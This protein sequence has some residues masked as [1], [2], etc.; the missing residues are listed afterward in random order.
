MKGE[1]LRAVRS[2]VGRWFADRM[3]PVWVVV[4]LVLL[5]VIE[6]W[7]LGAGDPDF[8]F[9]D[10]FRPLVVGLVLFFVLTMFVPSRFIR[11]Q[12]RIILGVGLVLGV[13]VAECALRTRDVDILESRIVMSDDPVLRYH[14]RPQAV[15]PD[16]GPGGEPIRINR[17]GL[18][19][20]AYSPEKREGVYRVV[21]LGDSVPNDGSIPFRQR[22]PHLLERLLNESEALGTIEVI[23]VS[24]EGYNTI[25]EVRLLETVGVQFDPDLVVLTYVLNDPFIQNGGY[26]RVGNSFLLMSLVQAVP[27]ML[28]ASACDLFVPLHD[29]YAFHLVVRTSFGRLGLR[30]R[31]HGF[32]VLVAVL[33]IVEEFDDPVCLSM[34]DQ[35]VALARE[36]GF[37]ALRLVDVF[38]GR[39]HREFYKAGAESD[40]THP[41]AEGHRLIAEAL[42]GWIRAHLSA[43]SP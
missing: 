23:N 22:F 1:R 33:P 26:R 30:A 20:R 39:D 41:N 29:R 7:A 27:P 12:L 32:A 35:V 4:L 11:A 37:P 42:A 16:T 8:Y 9:P 13:L 10:P 38:Q 36:N 28:G 43:G 18:W 3:G 17:F 21:V 14:Y 31:V 24:C 19:D 15:T 40:I 25:Q 2:T 6:I 34:Y 5:V